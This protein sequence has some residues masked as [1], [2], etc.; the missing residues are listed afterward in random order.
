MKR[1]ITII[2]VLLL[3]CVLAAIRAF[4]NVLFYDPLLDFFKHDYTSEAALP[5]LDFLKILLFTSL[6]FLMNTGISLLILWF[7]FRESATIKFA[8][9]L[10]VIAFVILIALFSY[11]VC[12]YHDG[13]YMALFYV[14]RFLIQPL[15]L[16]ILLPAFYYQKKIKK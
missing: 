16:I 14:R 1:A 13:N 15:L 5:D 9:L 4:E 2:I 12:N 3:F 11:L 7:C 8:A 10:Y 6:R